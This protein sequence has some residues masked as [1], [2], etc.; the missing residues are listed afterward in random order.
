MRYVAAVEGFAKEE[1]EILVPLVA[2][3][4]VEHHHPSVFSNVTL[5]RLSQLMNA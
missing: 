5:V 3:G 2:V 1:D 4:E